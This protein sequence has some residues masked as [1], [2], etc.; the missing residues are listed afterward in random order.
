MQNNSGDIVFRLKLSQYVVR[1]LGI[2][3]LTCGD[4]ATKYLQKQNEL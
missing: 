2:R 4:S 1:W 3:E